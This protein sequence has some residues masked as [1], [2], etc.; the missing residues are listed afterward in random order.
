MR[1]WYANISQQI[2][3][4]RCDISVRMS[5][6][7]LKAWDTIWR[8]NYA[9]ADLNA[10]PESVDLTQC[11]LEFAQVRVQWWTCCTYTCTCIYTCTQTP[12][13]KIGV[14]NICSKY[15]IPSYYSQDGSALFSY[16]KM[17][18]SDGN[19]HIV[20]VLSWKTNIFSRTR[21]IYNFTC[22]ILY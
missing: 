21:R 7:A 6:S 15:G 4:P 17:S 8:C 3:S 12:T 16:I 22:M 9:H 14:S 13:S 1:N 18:T 20:S 2:G 19:P 5:K 10:L 11:T